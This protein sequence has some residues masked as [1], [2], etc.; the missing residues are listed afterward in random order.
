MNIESLGIV[1]DASE[2][3]K[4]IAENPDLPI[5]VL[6]G[7][8]AATYEWAYT[9]CTDVRAH[10]GEILDCEVSTRGEYVIT[11][12][13]DLKDALDDLYCD[14]YADLSDDEYDKAIEAKIAEYE[15][16]WK[17]AIIVYADN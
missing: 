2:L 6:V 11:D 5:C 17:K 4:L 8:E 13:D 15:P 1:H 9:Y 7:R 3:R 14:E 16:F 10:I 12:R